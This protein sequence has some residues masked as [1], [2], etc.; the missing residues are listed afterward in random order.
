L[1]EAIKNKTRDVSPLLSQTGESIPCRVSTL[2][3]THLKHVNIL[4]FN[5]RGI[6]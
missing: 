4:F 3:D 1:Q 2:A 6:A 5:A